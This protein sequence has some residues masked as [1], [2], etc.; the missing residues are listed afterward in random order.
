MAENKA[1]QVEKT[2]NMMLRMQM[3]QFRDFS[4]VILSPF[5]LEVLVFSLLPGISGKCLEDVSNFLFGRVVP[6]QE[7][8]EAI[9]CY[10]LAVNHINALEKVDFK[11]N[12]YIYI[13]DQ[14][15]VNQN[16]V[17]FVY[18]NLNTRVKE[19]NFMDENLELYNIIDKDIRNATHGH[20]ELKFRPCKQYDG[21]FQSSIGEPMV[22]YTVQISHFKFC[23]DNPDFYYIE[24]PYKNESM[25]LC[26]ILPKQG[27]TL[28]S[29]LN[30]LN[31]NTLMNLFKTSVLTM[32]EVHLP[33]VKLQANLDLAYV[34]QIC[35]LTKVF[36]E[37]GADFSKMTTNPKGLFLESVMTNSDLF[38]QDLT[39]IS[40]S[41]H[42]LPEPPPPTIAPTILIDRPFMYFV[43]CEMKQ[44]TAVLF[45]GNVNVY[46]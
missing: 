41:I 27:Y 46:E 26:I 12:N 35:G 11:M 44:H 3:L 34:L 17:D 18:T 6:M 15:N 16:Y 10:K 2:V 38:L 5:S 42:M 43:N 37:E 32:C 40:T 28:R 14:Y 22:R 30:N 33:D 24:M 13:S 29:V 19:I 9:R 45:S 4:N 39:Q 8:N 1:F 20:C 21:K 7:V 36:E 25:N 31:Y 23:Q